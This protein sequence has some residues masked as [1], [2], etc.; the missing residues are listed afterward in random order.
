MATNTGTVNVLT[1]TDVAFS[2]EDWLANAFGN[3]AAFVNSSATHFEVADPTDFGGST[4]I[5]DGSG[6][7]YDAATKH[8]TKGAI[9]AITIH[10]TNPVADLATFS[11]SVGLKA[12]SLQTAALA[13]FN[14]GLTN[15]SA[16]DKTFKSV[17]WHFN[18]FDGND[19]FGNGTGPNPLGDTL[20][21]GVGNDVLFGGAGNDVL[22]GGA[23]NDILS[24]GAGNDTL[25]GGSGTNTASYGST[26][27]AVTVDLGISGV[28]QATGGAGTDTLLGI[29]NLTGGSGNDTLTGDGNANVIKGG[30]GDDVIEGRGGADTLD[31]EGGINT[32]SYAHDVTGVAVDLKAGTANVGDA[33]GDI[34]AN[35]RNLIGGSSGDGL[36]G[37][38]NDNKI[39]GGDGNDTLFGNKGN[40][41]VDGGAGDDFV[42]GGVGNDILSGG[43]GNELLGDTV[44][45]VNATG[46]GVTVNLALKTPQPVGGGLGTYTLSNFE[47]VGGS[48]QA[49]TLTGDKGNNVLEGAAGADSINGGGGS[50]TASYTISGTGVQIVLGAAGDFT[51]ATGGDAAGDT[52]TGIQNL[53]GS[54][55]VDQLTG[56]AGNNVI[57]GGA[58]ADV[59]NGG[60]GIDTVSYFHSNAAVTVVLGANGELDTNGGSVTGGDA[61]G[62][63]GG[64]FTNII[65]ALQAANVLTG[66]D[67]VNRIVGGLGPDTITGKGGA[68]FLD[69]GTGSNIDLLD[70]SY[71]GAVSVTA[72]LGEA[73]VQTTVTA[74]AGTDPAGDT[75]VNFESVSGGAG[76]DT[77]TGNS[78]SNTINGGAGDD[79]I[80]G[81][82][83][84]I[85]TLIGGVG[86][87]D[88]LSYASSPDGV[89]VSLNGDVL[90]GGNFGGDALGDLIQ[91]FEK[92]VGSTFGDVLRGDANANTIVG[93][94]GNDVIE[95]RDGA[96]TLIGGLGTGDDVRYFFSPTAV[97]IDLTQQGTTDAQGNPLA[98]GTAQQGGDAAGDL[99]WGFE[100]IAGSFFN[101]V[102]TGDAKANSIS[103]SDG[104][105]TIIGGAGA[106]VLDGGAGTDLLSYTTDTKGVTVA[107]LGG[108]SH[109]TGKGGDAE[110]D[111][112]ANFE[113]LT[114][115]SG[116]DSLTGSSFVNIIHGG[117]GNDTIDG[118]AGG[119]TLD[120]DGGVNTL[121]YAISIQ[122]VTVDL[123][124]GTA[125]GGDAQGDTFTNFANLLGSKANDVLTGTTGAEQIDGSEGDDLIDA[126]GA[127]AGTDILIGGLGNDTV[128]YANTGGVTVSLATTA[129]QATGGYGSEKLSG[130]ENIIGSHGVD[131]LTGTSG[132]NIIEGGAGADILI[133]NG[134]ADTVSYA[135]D[136]T[137]VTVT[138]GASGE[139]NAN[140][141]AVSGGDAQGDTGGGF[142]N[143]IGGT[144]ADTLNGNAG[145][146]IIEGGAGADVMDGK[147]GSNT[148]SYAHSSLGVIVTLG[149][150]GTIAA[151]S[152]GDAA[153]DTG[154]N[155]QNLLGSASF[156]Q[157]TGNDGANTISG[158]DGVDTLNGGK[159]N[160]TIDGGNSGDLINGGAGAD[161]LIGGAGSDILLFN[162]SSAGVTVT[163][164]KGGALST[165]VGGDAEGDKISGFENINGS[166]H[167]DV[168]TGNELANQ[169]SGDSGND[170][171]TGG[172][173]SDTLRGN[174]GDDILEGGAGA[175]ILLGDYVG[176]SVTGSDTA[177]YASSAKGV[178]VDL[179]LQSLDQTVAQAVQDSDASGD[180]LALIDNLR[181]SA[182]ADMLT[183]DGFDNIIE[184]G[185]G[186]DTL[187]AGGG[188]DTVS[189][190]HSSAGVTVDLTLEGH[191]FLIPALPQVSGG[192]AAGDILFDFEN[193]VG[194]AKVDK[195][196]GDAHDNVID[197]GAGASKDTLIGNAG[198]DVLEGGG[199]ADILHG[200]A[201]TDTVS[202][203]RS[204]AAVTV[205]LGANGELDSNGGS[206]SGGDAAGDTGDGF[207]NIR[208]GTAD[209][210][211]TGNAGN[212]TIEGGAGAD[213]MDGLGGF[214]ILSYEH[215]Q[216]PVDIALNDNGTPTINSGGD[217]NGDQAFNFQGLMGGSSG[218]HLI[219]DSQTN[220]LI[221]NGGDDFL[222]PGFG[223]G[224]S[225]TLVG[226]DGID[227]ADYSDAT[228]AV[229]FDLGA[230]SAVTGTQNDS[231]DSIETVIGGSHGDTFD[232][233]GFAGSPSFG[234][235][236]GLVNTFAP[237]EGND[238]ITG[239]GHTT[240]SYFA[241]GQTDGVTVDLQGGTATGTDI[242]NDTITGGVDTVVGT[243]FSDQFTG[244]DSAAT[245]YFD[246]RGGSD[247]THG[248]GGFD[249]VIFDRSGPAVTIDLAAG[250]YVADAAGN[251]FEI[252]GVRG[253]DGDDVF[254]ATGFDKNS[255]NKGST[256]I[257]FNSN[258]T[259]NE[260]EGLGGSDTIT[261]N[262]DTRVAFYHANS[263]VDVDLSNGTVGGGASATITGGVNRVAGSTFDDFLTGNGSNDFLDGWLGN[264]E[265][266][267][268][269]GSDIFIYSIGNSGQHQGGGNDGIDS[270]E[271]GI[272]H[273]DLRGVA[274]VHNYNDLAITEAG[275]NST[276]TFSQGNTLT[277]FAVSKATLDAHQ[278]DFL[279]A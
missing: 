61:Q 87:F 259:L 55:H 174:D 198:D 58:G 100:S 7:A 93:G 39:S 191:G 274:T 160:D 207:E 38:D 4:L 126:W 231:L 22:H 105:D 234:D 248:L 60:G 250:S 196:T 242:G 170:V 112:I 169:L 1:A 102:L 32:L 30:A 212:N 103:G 268:G 63:T 156:D 10:D 75:I 5:F 101:D 110:G 263:G 108:G 164:G 97:T 223:A 251:F 123:G 23:D 73:G 168:L 20:N 111:D 125:S 193:I 262:G 269:S 173:G 83:G 147:G 82:A 150:G 21:G 216:S 218:D 201:D 114:G 70:Y 202:Y 142:Q 89:V 244:S 145:D 275:G 81:G 80:A 255:T 192:D 230:G 264:D 95:G 243:Q 232:A 163:L 144:N 130:F 13:Y 66:N 241:I 148:L 254:V 278:G 159:G 133:G 109:S 79:V 270:Y 178:T 62:D 226:G 15:H 52:A 25:D 116:N 91:G 40:D 28:A 279:F 132:N 143:I 96:D 99:L 277:F 205:T 138:L 149:A 246:G 118:G 17:V 94:A 166:L 18:G 258:G 113:N 158:G 24:G 220:V 215:T 199:G 224:T 120:G 56:N 57:E 239:S 134:G 181:G 137:G 44:S 203:A 185:A 182:H 151:A 34:I 272:D 98:A 92:L 46:T 74:A 238:T 121:S 190:E 214:N 90:T 276:I 183:G 115:G 31:G 221:G 227:T 85:D 122:G 257:P 210:T 77:L 240:L 194:S 252:E 165:G 155:F 271:A 211:L 187:K 189:Y 153:G 177:S 45:F 41:T 6:F 64:G 261:G 140:G 69:G 8:V 233:T 119:D 139:L 249:V 26:A 179:N 11:F 65:G 260:F 247:T 67:S 219:G 59:L 237:G 135:H 33:T 209:D 175:D 204:A 14:S 71:L 273:V 256:D 72:Q 54:S 35:F 141:G 128:R 235:E 208:G 51:T 53:L 48:N 27:A 206:V 176:V 152:G 136:T 29:E 266:L 19:T 171:L 186:A 213:T 107:I 222:N 84:L 245:E 228:A 267:G 42:V 9:T 180:F 236:A 50:D 124:Q 37:D 2:I 68:D 197:G 86:G 146:N 104:A 167:D 225:D 131:K 106:D 154:S 217:A 229:T 172:E 43:S 76:N 88:T 16:L 184:G 117:G 162:T 200:G 265:M 157:L 3:G 195:L 36:T 129:V 127:A 47:N 49:D 12:A 161:I 78:T 188:N 253:T